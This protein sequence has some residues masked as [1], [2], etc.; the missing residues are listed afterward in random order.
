M[1]MQN[2]MGYSV[3]EG[4]HDPAAANDPFSI[5]NAG[6]GSD[7]SQDAMNAPGSGMGFD[8]T[9]PWE[10]VGLGLE[11]PMPTSEAVNEL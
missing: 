9:F 7:L 2:G 6:I 3:P 5:S 8:D 4:A 10:M 1:T 11:E